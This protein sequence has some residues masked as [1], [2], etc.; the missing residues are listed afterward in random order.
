MK[1]T[2]TRQT[3][4]GTLNRADDEE[5]R[6]KQFIRDRIDGDPEKAAEFVQA[7]RATMRNSKPRRVDA[8]PWR[9]IIKRWQCGDNNVCF[10]GIDTRKKGKADLVPMVSDPG[11]KSRGVRIRERNWIHLDYTMRLQPSSAAEFATQ[12]EQQFG[13]Q[14]EPEE[15]RTGEHPLARQ[16]REAGAVN[17]VFGEAAERH[18][19][20]P[21]AALKYFVAEVRDRR[22]TNAALRELYEILALKTGQV[23]AS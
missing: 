5:E 23:R 10:A 16:M 6:V 14:L 1:A 19:E 12:L 13:L 20:N 9:M 3:D 11:D 8:G 2:G 22:L 21:E 4:T 18:S 15:E 7:I 17:I